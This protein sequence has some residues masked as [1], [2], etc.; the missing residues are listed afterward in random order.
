EDILADLM[1]RARAG[2]GARQF[3][4][5]GSDALYRLPGDFL[6]AVNGAS[7]RITL[8]D[9]GTL[10]VIIPAGT[11]DAQVLRLRGKGQPGIGGGPPGG[12]PVQN[13]ERPHTLFNRNDD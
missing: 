8:P 11:H 6:E 1:G 5:R 7:K 12:E 9:G 13:E 2:Q 3:R 10:D 4:M